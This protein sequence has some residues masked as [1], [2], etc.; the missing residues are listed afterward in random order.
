MDPIALLLDAAVVAVFVLT[1]AIFTYRGFTKSAMG[2]IV[3]VASFILCKM[4]GGVVGEW[5]DENFFHDMLYAKVSE[6]LNSTFGEAADA[7][8]ADQLFD[9]MPDTLK[10]IL[11]MAGA[12]IADIKTHLMNF[13]GDVSS[14]IISISEKITTYISTAVCDL[15]GYVSVFIGSYVVLRI[16]SFFI[17]KFMELPI[18]HTVNKIGG[19]LLGIISGCIICWVLCTLFV[20]I[21]SF[22]SL[23]YPA[24]EPFSDISGTY[25]FSIFA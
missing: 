2:F 11:D 5:L 10:N 23:T 24:L 14:G 7:M 25:I 4:F 12:D 17:V 19:F 18:L 21:I 22:L 8:S 3:V 20:M 13:E 15:L 16:L 1:V 9:S 6:I